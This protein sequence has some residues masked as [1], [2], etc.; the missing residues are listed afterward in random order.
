MKKLEKRV[1]VVTGGSRGIGKGI[2]LRFAEEG[3]DVAFCYHVNEEEAKKTKAE[4]EA[5]GVKVLAVKADVS[6][7]DAVKSFAE[8]VKLEFGKVNILV[9][10][11]GY[12]GI[13]TPITEL[14]KAEWDKVLGTDIGGVFLNCKHFIPIFEKGENAP[15]GKII[16]IS[17]E[18]SKLGREEYTHYTASKGAINTFTYSLALELCPDI[19][20]NAI[21]PGPIA[22]DMIVRDKTPEWIAIEAESTLL[23]RLGKIEEVSATALLLA[24]DDGDYFVGQLLSPNGGAVFF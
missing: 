8:K 13:E 16:N 11:A 9:N 19:L 4:C 15:V 10:N 18:L 12:E 23:K 5:F 1:A 17:S 3:A 20:V 21:L 24:S 6:D 14:T 22:T 7:E 2:A